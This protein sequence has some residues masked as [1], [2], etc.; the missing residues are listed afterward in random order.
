MK[1]II[2]IILS[3]FLLIFLFESCTNEGPL[4]LKPFDLMPYGIPLTILA[5]DSADVKVDD[6]FVMK[7]ITVKKGDDYYI[8]ILSSNAGS[9]DIVRLLSD[10]RNSVKEHQYFSRFIEDKPNGFV[11]EMIIDSTEYSYDFRH[12]RV[13]G[14]KEYICQTGLIGSFTLEEARRMYDSID[15]EMQKK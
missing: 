7:D 2:T 13:K 9:N 12:V 4:E 1:H 6:L 15:Y 8:Q 10:Q 14:D 3:A 5:P 11:Y